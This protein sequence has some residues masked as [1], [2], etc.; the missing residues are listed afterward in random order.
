L[1]VVSY[2]FREEAWRRAQATRL[3]VTLLFTDQH[4]W[5]DARIVRGY[6][7]Q[8]HVEGAF[9]DLKDTEH[10]A[11]RP[12]RHWTDQKIR[13][14][15]YCCVLALLLGG[16]LRRELDRKGIQRSLPAI[17]EDLGQIQEVCLAYAPADGAEP[18]F[19]V[20]LTQMTEDQKALYDALDL[21]RYR[22]P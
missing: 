17:L 2:R 8:H 9:R 18:Q 1:P 21:G 19:Q 5:P 10:L 6:R 3:G 7:S 15:V 20:T 11:L 14:H 16:L 22:S 12:Q 13:V 4:A